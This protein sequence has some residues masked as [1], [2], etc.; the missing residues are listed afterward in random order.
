MCCVCVCCVFVWCVCVCVCVCVVNHS[1]VQYLKKSFSHY[2]YT[3]STSFSRFSLFL[4]SLWGMRNGESQIN[5]QLKT[6][7]RTSFFRPAFH[8]PIFFFFF[9]FFRKIYFSHSHP[10]IIFLK[11]AQNLQSTLSLNVDLFC[12]QS[13]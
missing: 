10:Q 3:S 1:Q 8:C 6:S 12:I 13:H 7:F 2:Y 11:T 9:F 5:M 4:F